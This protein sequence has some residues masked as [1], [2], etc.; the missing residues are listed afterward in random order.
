MRQLHTVSKPLDA[1]GF[2]CGPKRALNSY[3]RADFS[4]VYTKNQGTS[5]KQSTFGFVVQLFKGK[6]CLLSV[7]PALDCRDD[8]VMLQ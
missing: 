3:V 5:Q 8:R 7:P 6:A 2:V 1:L 4:N